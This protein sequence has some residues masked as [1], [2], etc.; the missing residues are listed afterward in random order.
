MLTEVKNC[1]IQGRLCLEVLI[2]DCGIHACYCQIAAM[3]ALRLEVTGRGLTGV[4]GQLWCLDQY[5]LQYS[6]LK[7]FALTAGAIAFFISREDLK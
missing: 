5:T 6:I 7:I 4:D 3:H 1:R 2:C